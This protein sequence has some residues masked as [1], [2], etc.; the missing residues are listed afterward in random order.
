MSD[1]PLKFAENK[2]NANQ[3][4]FIAIVAMLIDH[5]ALSFLP[6]QSFLYQ[7]MRAI[8][9][10][11]MPIMCYFIAEGYYKT[12]N[13]KRYVLRLSLFSILSHYSFV[14]FISGISSISFNDGFS[15]RLVLPTSVILTL[16][17]GLIGLII[18]NNNRINKY[19]KIVILMWL[20]IFSQ[21]ADWG[22][23]GVLLVLAFG[24]YHNNFKKQVKCFYMISIILFIDT[25]MLSLVN[26]NIWWDNLYHL[27]ILLA[28]P[29]LSQYDGTLGKHKSKWLFYI[30]YP[31]HL[32]ILGYLRY[33]LI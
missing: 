25:I 31:L 13:L 28:I 27:G 22:Y 9:R 2:F 24:I 33:V 16:L 30:F 11:T 17:I 3:L 7:I 8:G 23:I 6:S 1:I 14:M 20:C 32:L 19:V 5:I 4:K 21:I 10:V 15:I 12:R 18:Y 26:N 29:L